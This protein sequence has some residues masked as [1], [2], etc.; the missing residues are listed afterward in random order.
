MLPTSI[1]RHVIKPETGVNFSAQITQKDNSYR[2]FRD[3][4]HDEK[5]SIFP[6]ACS[7]LDCGCWIRI[8]YAIPNGLLKK[9]MR[10]VVSFLVG[11]DIR[12]ICLKNQ[13][14]KKILIEIG[15]YDRFPELNFY[16]H[17]AEVYEAMKCICRMSGR[18][19]SNAGKK[20]MQQ[21]AFLHDA[22]KVISVC[23]AS[24]HR[25]VKLQKC[26]K[27]AWDK[28]S[29]V[30]LFG[31]KSRLLSGEVFSFEKLL[32]LAPELIE[33][34]N[35][36]DFS[37]SYSPSDNLVRT[38]VFRK[39][40]ADLPVI[41]LLQVPIPILKKDSKEADFLLAVLDIADKCSD[42]I[43]KGC[44]SV[45]EILV[46]LS[47]KEVYVGRRYRPKSVAE[48]ELIRNDFEKSRLNLATI[49][50]R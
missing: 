12:A 47:K 49:F 34:S 24:F 9:G 37:K 33:Y 29:D 40:G 17:I 19:I 36:I 21:L 3:L 46:A 50:E 16:G 42:Y 41:R 44:E 13:L 20:M 1:V 18:E 27:A 45:N 23:L 2:F 6:G 32:S 25:I 30:E 26:R 22:G 35:L 7:G 31:L 43:P 15:L 8:S 11:N 39:S 38:F 14:Y 10:R 48:K 4:L 28:Y 5:V